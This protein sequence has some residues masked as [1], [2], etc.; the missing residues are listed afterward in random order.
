[1]EETSHGEKV[2]L[3]VHG[4]G[5]GAGIWGNLD[6]PYSTL[7]LANKIF[8]G[9]V[10]VANYPSQESIDKISGEL[11]LEMERIRSECGGRLPDMVVLGHCMGG[12]V[13]RAMVREHPDYF[14]EIALVGVPNTGLHFGVLTDF[15]FDNYSKYLDCLWS[16]H[17]ITLPV[18][19]RGKKR[20]AIDDLNPNGDFIKNLNAPT[21]PLNVTYHFFMFKSTEKNSFFIPGRDDSLI[22]PASAFP[23]EIMEGE[24]FENIRQGHVVCF[25]GDVNHHTLMFNPDIIRE[26]LTTLDQGSPASRRTVKIDIPI[27][28][29][30]EIEYREEISKLRI[31]PESLECIHRSTL[32][33]RRF[34]VPMASLSKPAL[35]STSLNSLLE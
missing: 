15:I 30:H 25:K 33:Y 12:V 5:S 26:I 34:F 1:M 23:Q 11:I 35:N 6:D 24:K 8:N 16:P 7:S 10:L 3:L 31:E 14:K 18:D 20:S 19:E 17:G 2:V 21:D 27:A 4:F 29:P 22:S 13:I 28:P 9:R 32:I